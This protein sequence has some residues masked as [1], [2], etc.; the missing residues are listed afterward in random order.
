MPTTTPLTDAIQALTQ[1]ANETTGA[2]DTTLSAAVGTLVAGYGGG[3]GVS[4]D[5]IAKTVQPSGAITLSDSV[6]TIGEYAFAGKPI[7]SITGRGVTSIVGQYSLQNTQIES[8]TDA[9]FPSLGV[10]SRY[11]VLFKMNSLKTIKLSG[12]QI[13]LSSG[14]YALRDNANL[15]RAEFPNAAYNVGPSYAVTAQN[16]FGGCKKLTT[17]DVGYVQRIVGNTFNGSTSLTTIV[18]RY[19]S[20]VTLDNVSAFNNT[21]FKNGG[22]GGE[23]Y[24]PSA[25]ISSYQS[26]TNWSTVNGWGTITWKAIEGSEWEL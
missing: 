13:V 16:A 21:P 10:S 12:E 23:I 26:A 3:G 24:V 2:S 5:D 19:S 1:Y 4:I 11:A 8:I 7:T 25:L 14:Y 20:V 6:T 18:L 17:V 9:N 22:T 15:E